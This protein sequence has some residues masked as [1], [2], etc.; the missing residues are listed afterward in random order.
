MNDL[1]N[2]TLDAM[3]A[4]VA[5]ADGPAGLA[6]L[7]RDKDSIL[8]VVDGMLRFCV[9]DQAYRD[10][11]HARGDIL[12]D[13]ILAKTDRSEMLIHPTTSLSR[14]HGATAIHGLEDLAVRLEVLESDLSVLVAHVRPTVFLGEMAIGQL[15]ANEPGDDPDVIMLAGRR[16]LRISVIAASTEY[17]DGFGIV[18]DEGEMFSIVLP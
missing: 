14:R 1:I 11:V 13:A 7:L 8:D 5:A 2:R 4:R 12:R 16:V 15:Q 17:T 3:D 18:T 9:V 6:I 10:A